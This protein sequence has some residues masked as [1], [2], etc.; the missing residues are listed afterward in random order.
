M[1][2]LTVLTGTTA[3]NGTPSAAT[4]GV[5]LWR[6]RVNGEGLSRLTDRAVCLVD[7]AATATTAGSVT[8]K[9]WGYNPTATDWFPL[10][11]STTAAN[12]G[13]LNEETALD[14]TDSD[15]IQHSEIV[16]GLSAFTRIYAELTAAANLDSLD[17]Y[18]TGAF[19]AGQ[20][21]GG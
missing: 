4:D 8:V 18:L 17:I 13:L 1:A 2:N 14:E 20:H 6:T 12:K 19:N 16:Q 7:G 21:Y 3:A 10:G 5:A 15:K 11:T 9:L